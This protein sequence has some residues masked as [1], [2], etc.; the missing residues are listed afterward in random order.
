LVAL[1]IQA[2]RAGGIRDK[3]YTPAL[4]TLLGIFRIQQVA[5]ATY[6]HVAFLCPNQNPMIA[7]IEPRKNSRTVS[8]VIAR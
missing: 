3:L 8:V 5:M 7:E 6:F 2:G 1:F 4:R